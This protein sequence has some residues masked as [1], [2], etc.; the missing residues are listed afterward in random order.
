VSFGTSVEIPIQGARGKILDPAGSMKASR[1]TLAALKTCEDQAGF[2]Q[3][4]A[5]QPSTRKARVQ[6]MIFNAISK[7][8][9]SPNRRSHDKLLLIDAGFHDKAIMIT[10][11]RNISHCCS[12]T[13]ETNRSHP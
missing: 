13:R 8:S 1:T 6:V 10:G 4:E 9:T 11:G 3:T 7:I 2:I 5:G 12:Y